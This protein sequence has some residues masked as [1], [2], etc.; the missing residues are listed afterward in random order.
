[1]E[2]P[3][4]YVGREQSYLKH[5]VLSEY[6]RAWAQKHASTVRFKGRVRLC[7]VD[8]LA[9]PW[10]TQDV[11]L[12]DTSVSIGLNALK[13]ATARWGANIEPVAVFVEKD[14]KR[15]SALE[16]FL[17]AQAPGIRRVAIEG[18][19][20]DHVVKINKEIGDSPAFLFVDPTGWDGV[21]M[22]Y[23]A[24]LARPPQRDVMINVM[25]NFMNRFLEDPRAFLRAQIR[26]FFGLA[27]RD[28]PQGLSESELFEFYKGQLRAQAGVT[29]AA[30]LAIPHPTNA[31][32]WFHLVVGGHHLRVLELFRDVER[33]V[34]GSEAV[35][36]RREARDRKK[37]QSSLALDQTDPYFDKF[38]QADLIQA[39]KV[40]SSNPGGS[41]QL[42]STISEG[43][44]QRFH[45]ARS[46][47]IEILNDLESEG[48][49]RVARD[50]PR[51]KT[52]SNRALITWRNA[53][54]P[55][56]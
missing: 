24:P 35:T 19:F 9:G 49:V 31:R 4:A 53:A 48:T 26:D 54:I 56:G 25:F 44:L 10:E 15:F 37:R 43:L 50:N 6:L 21:A 11:E 47:V 38:R 40:L 55:G 18:A 30:N 39:R 13:E 51:S 14:P 32:T 5:R 28:I 12:R 45:M 46:D 42:L 20:G 3:G 22:N 8:C 7:Y 2:M 41:S 33:K 1:M 27:D 23:I 29:F 52:I 36:V 34:C 17:A 16:A